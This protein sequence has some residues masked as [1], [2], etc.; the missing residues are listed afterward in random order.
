M[1]FGL[2]K[3][4]KAGRAWR[5]RARIVDASGSPVAGAYIYVK[6]G[7]DDTDATF[8]ADAEGLIDVWLPALE[9]GSAR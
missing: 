9:R 3:Q 7:L 2:P 5:A 6:D 8:F 1:A 4:V